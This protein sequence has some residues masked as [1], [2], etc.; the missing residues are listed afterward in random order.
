[1]DTARWRR[2]EEL[3]ESAVGLEPGRRGAF[4]AEA[5]AG[6]EPLRQEVESLVAAF[7]Q[8]RDFLDV[9]ALEVIAASVAGEEALQGAEA[10]PAG[11][12]IGPYLTL[13]ALGRG[14]MGEVYKAA[15]TRLGRE[16]A[17]KFLPEQ[18]SRDARA[19]ERFTRE[20]RAVSALNH[21]N[22]CVL[23]D[24]G[25]HVGRPFL[26]LELLEGRS[27]KDRIAAGP[28]PPGE[29][30]ELAIQITGALQA[31]HARGI[32]HRDIKPGN[33]FLTGAPSGPVQAKILDFG[34]VK[35]AWD[36]PPGLSVASVETGGDKAGAISHDDTLSRTGVAMGT[37]TYVSPEQARG[38]EVD[39]RTDLFS[40]GATLYEAAT[41]CSPFHRATPQATVEAILR[42]QPVRPRELVRQL[43]AELE[44]IILK[45]VEKD[46][47][48]RYQ[49]AAEMHSDLE[50][51]KR[52]SAPGLRSLLRKPQVAVPA[53]LLMVAVLAA[54]TWFGIHSRRARWARSVALPEIARLV[55]KLDF[56][57]TFRLARQAERY[58]A[59]DPELLR[60]QHHYRIRQAVRTDPPGAEV[61][62]KGYLNVHASWIYLGKSP[63]E[64]ARIPRGHDRWKVAKE[65]F[66]PVEGAFSSYTGLPLPLFKLHTPSA[67]PPGMIRVP[68]GSLRVRSLPPVQSPDYWL[69]KYEVSN[70]QFKEFVDRGGYQKREYW[71]HPFVKAG[72]TLSWEQAMAEFRDATGRPGP[73]TWKLGTYPE[74]QDDFP[75][76]GVSW[77]EAA[78]YAEFAGKTL[79]T[80]YRN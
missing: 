36:K 57:S 42:Q 12:Q 32:I 45:A 5:C 55:D 9:P 31:A 64:S 68:G 69:D 75:A 13:G 22:I 48:A 8:A 25:V 21:P 49:S 30:L 38:E 61:Y 56:D 41:G 34:L 18:S 6:D 77:Y 28:L 40:L 14:G 35:L 52:R 72:K 60:L 15:D 17:L 74:G 59:G 58:I 66:E 44:R 7:E 1:M 46:R 79:P 53:V 50:R 43:P 37:L 23:H 39:A 27:L 19:L 3:Y 29:L 10:L 62:V 54:G 16:V 80:F 71:K 67:A 47:A 76:S 65:G 33:V 78:A 26:V 2:V 20:A 11:L 4:L 73:S 70:K 24:I 63:I 51:L